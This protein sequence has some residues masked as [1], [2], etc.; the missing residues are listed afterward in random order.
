MKEVVDMNV[1]SAKKTGRSM[2]SNKK[3]FTKSKSKFKDATIEQ[4]VNIVRISCDKVYMRLV[5]VFYVLQ[6][7]IL[8]QKYLSVFWASETLFNIV[9]N[10]M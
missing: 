6:H 1:P 2:V 8:L 3:H 10:L 7:I 4:F 5:N 9:F